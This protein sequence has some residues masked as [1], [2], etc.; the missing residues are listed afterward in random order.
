M[1]KHLIL[2]F[3]AVI[4]ACCSAGNIQAQNCSDSE[5]C[6]YNPA[7]EG[8]VLNAPCLIVETVVE[9]TEGDLA[10]MTTYR[11]FF[12][13]EMPT[14]FVTSVYGNLGTP[15]TLT[16]TTTFYQN[17][18]G[19]ASSQSQNPLL[20]EGFPNL[21]YDS[22]VTIGLSETANA[23]A[24]ESNP[25][26]VPSPNQD[27]IS[28]FDPGGGAAGT[29][30][31]INDIVGGIWYIFNGDANGLPDENNRVLLAQ[32]TT[33]GE[34]G[35]VLNV[36]YFPN[37]GDA[38]TATLSIADAC[39]ATPED[40][41]Y[42]E[43]NEDC[44]GNCLN[45]QDADQICDEVDDCIGTLDACGVC[46][47]PGAVLDCG[48]SEI[49]AGDCDCNGNQLDA[50]GDCGGDCESDLNGNGV[51]DT[52]EN[53]GCTDETAC[54]Y[55]PNATNDDG[56]CAV[57]DA[58][59]VC[60]GPGAVY[61]C[62]CDEQPAGDCDCDGNQ[63]DALGVCGGDCAADADSDGVCD[64][65]D[66]CVGTVDECGVCNGPGAT[67]DCGCDDLPDGACDCDGNVL[68]ALGVCGGSCTADA[69]S[70]GVCD[71]VD[72]CIGTLDACG[73]C[74]G[75]GAIY[76]CGCDEQPAGDCDCDGNQ[77]DA[78]G[79]C[80]GDCP[81]DAD[82]N[83]ICDNLEGSG[84]GD[85]EACN[86]DEFADPP[87]DEPI[88]DYC[89]I[90]EV[91]ATHTD[92][93]LAGMTTYRV[94]VQTLHPTDFLTSVSGN[95]NI[96]LDIST[97]T[98]FYQN[99]LGGATP[100]NV[101][102]LLLPG[103]PDLAY[104]SWVTIGLDGPAN[105]VAGESSATIVNSPNQ[106]WALQFEPGFGAPGGSIEIDDEVGGVWYVLNG[107]A[108]G[109]PDAD[110][111]ILIGQFTTDGELSGT[112]NAQVFPEG[113][114]VNF[115]LLTL[116]IGMGIGCPSGGGGDNCL[117]DDAL[118]ACGGD[119]E[120]DA[121]G[122]GICDDVDDCVGELDACGV[123]NGPGAVYDCGC[124]EQPSGDCDCDGNQSDALGVCGGDCAADADSDGVC[125]N[126]DDCVGTV[127]ECGVCNGPGA[128]GDCGCDD[129]PDGACDC[130]GNV[131]DALGVCGGS[132]TADADSDGVCDNVD[133]CIGTVDAC[134]ICNGPGAIYDCGCDEQPAGDCD[135][136]GNQLDAL[137]V[138]GGDCPA[139]ADQNGICDNIEGSGCGDPEA[140]NFDEFA[141]PPVDEPITDYCTI[142]EVVAT[143]TDGDLAG[144]TTYRVYVQTLHPTDFL[145]SVSGNVN[146]PLDISTTTTFYQN[147]LGGATPENVNPLLL[148][149]FPDLAYDSW[150]TIGL[151]GPANAVAGESSATIVNSP[152]QNWA[153]QFEPGFGAPGGNI[154][155]D[156]EVGGVWYVLNG[157]ANGLPDAD[158]RILIGQFTTD[159]ELS[160]TVN[161][162]VFPEGDNVN[163]LVLTLP[164]GMGVGCPSNNTDDSCLYDDVLGVCG[165]DCEADADGDGIC[166]D[167]DDCV[168]DFD[169]CGICNGPGAIYDCGC[170]EQPSDDCDCDGNQLDA[171]GVCGGDCEADADGD[172]ICDD[173]D[174]CVGELD[175]CGICNGPGAIYDCGCDEQPSDDCDCDGNQLDALGVCGGDCE[176]DADGDGICDDVDDCVGELDACGVCNGPGA[177]Y[178]C[179]CDEQPAD[180]CDCDGNQ[181]DA[182]GV[183]GGD[184]EADAD[185]DGICDDVDDCVGDLDACGICNGPG[186]IYDCGCDEQPSDD[187]DC[188]G[189]QLDA[190]GVCGGDCPAD[191]D[192]DG[193]CDN[194]EI[195][196]CTLESAC[197][198]NP[199][200]TDD[201]GSCTTLDECGVCGGDGIADGDC[202]CD[203]NQL[204][205][206]GVCGGG[207]T[208]DADA[209]G[210]CDDVDDCVGDLDAC[211]VCNGPGAIY[212]CGC[213][214]QPADD[215]D[216]DGNQ[217]DALGV[218]GGDCPSDVDGDGVCDNAEIP[219]CTTESACNYNPLATDDDGSCAVLD[220][221]GDCGG[222]CPSDLNGDGICD[223]DNVFG[224]TEPSACNFNP[225]ADVNNGSC[226]FFS[227]LGCTDSDA[228]NFDNAATI[229][230]GS[231]LFSGCINP[232]ASNYD[233]G[234]DVD[235]GSCLFPGCTD[236]TACN[237]SAQANDEDNSCD[238]SCYGCTNQTA[239]NY[240][241]DATVND[242]SCEFNSCRG[243]TDPDAFNYDAGATIDDNSCLYEGCTNSEA[244]NFD[245]NADINDGSCLYPGCDDITA[246]NYD[247]QANQND[248]S[249]DFSCYGCINISA[250]NYDADATVSDGSCEFVSCRGCTDPDAINFEVGS[251]ID[252]GSCL[253]SGCNDPEAQNYDAN[254]DFNDGSCEYPG[255]LDPAAC[256][257]DVDANVDDGSCDLI[258]CYGC[259]NPAACNYDAT[260]TFPDGSCDLVTCRGCT[261][262]DAINY[263]L[264]ATIDNGS[265]LFTG[266]TDPDASNYDANA[267]Y[268]DGSCIYTGCTN[269][270]ACNFNSSATVDDGSCDTESC[271][272]CIN[273]LA[274]NYDDTAT[275][276]DGSCDLFSCR[277]CT[278]PDAINYDNAATIDDGSCIVVGCLDPEAE[279][280]NANADYNDPD[281]C[282][283]PVVSGC[284]VTIACNYNP[285]ATV[286]DG[287]CDYASCAGCTDPSATN[288]DDTATLND[289][290]CA[291]GMQIA[292]QSMLDGCTLPFACNFGDTENPCEFDSCT[293][294]TVAGA[295]NYDPDATLA[296]TC[297]YPEDLCNGATNVDC[298]CNCL[299]DA[300][301]NQICDEDETGG[302]TNPISCNYDPSAAFDD[303]SCDT[304][305]CG[306][307]TDDSACN[308]DDQALLN[309]GSCDYTSCTG[310]LD[311]AAC[312]YSSTAT[313]ADGSCTYAQEYQDCDGNCLN[314]A[315]SNNIC[316]EYEEEGC[317]DPFACN[318]NSNATI[319]N[320]SCES[321]SCAGCTDSV[322]CNYDQDAVINNGSC[323]YTSCIG[324]TDGTACNY[325]AAATVSS[326]ECTY[327][328][329]AYVDCNGDCLEDANQNGLCDPLEV[330]GCTNT[331][332]CNYNADANLDDGS[333]D[334]TSC[335]GCLDATACNYDSAATQS[336]GNCD[337]ASCQG[338]NDAAACNYDATATQDDG[339]CTYPA[340]L[341]L[342]CNGDCVNDID[343]DGVCDELE[344]PGCDDAAACNYSSSA[345][346]NDGSCDYASCLGCVDAAA[347]NYDAAATQSDGSCDFE[348]C[349]GCMAPN[350]CN[351]D[352]TATQGD[353]SCT[354]PEGLLLDCDGGCINDAD[355][356]GVCDEQETFGC[357]EVGACNFNALATENNG[358][359]DFDSCQGC[360]VPSACNYDPAA[361]Q[362]DGSCDLSG[363]L[364][365]TYADALNYDADATED[366]GSCLFD[367]TGG[368]G[369]CYG[370]LTDDGVIGIADLLEFLIVFDSTCAD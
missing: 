346:D 48:C 44:S 288:Y 43:P 211:G 191:V 53:D 287:N 68:D 61:D 235:D 173:V 283:Y 96:P 34:L 147:L 205:A 157:D 249:C 270:F 259:L 343:G 174:D 176:A 87:V 273:P 301:N 358:S 110:G 306:G 354:Y 137:G 281:L 72:D 163:F 81:A 341:L 327:P 1:M 227:C 105:A 297:F 266:C 263:D 149:G 321:I 331:D 350:A 250:C 365:C 267:D 119:C 242:G 23:S 160:G 260:A 178:D 145:T 138:C 317:T 6:N 300:N 132:C 351:Y 236:I 231:C 216:C 90:T 118:G 148:P 179:G 78:L 108:N 133:D 64:N 121:D 222:D 140:C 154:E 292:G 337:Y 56:S 158:G 22:Y 106:N 352:P 368:G 370:D 220:A 32:L 310:C 200:A 219:G 146:I 248:N 62:G 183:C 277:G 334:L 83:G 367:T 8:G 316:D 181:L 299:N 175:A 275:L 92:G 269:P 203:G 39:E 348:S 127:D 294:C 345:T 75:P 152:N 126:V 70:D 291:Y 156:D 258:S 313:V 362:N 63:P 134:G 125:D 225:A 308:Y 318:F 80:G 123:C 135:C 84:C 95:V 241:L 252:D 31:I 165:G 100:E 215:C 120:A 268:S 279:N 49:P 237:Y 164:I 311:N 71:N 170:D 86:F 11:V 232:D 218:C 272:G 20:F 195:P 187:C 171:L 25:S 153:L 101:N 139:D 325:D 280:Y 111:R 323:D 369:S 208:A 9:H 214:E 180:D 188:D 10:G 67:G 57:V 19:S 59:G 276:S 4:A 206:I 233:A 309:D 329:S 239:C 238:F 246:C 261:N 194:A 74:N 91:V 305:S 166:D 356:D 298:D 97:T 26:L 333:C 28:A 24:G 29:D 197:N 93:D 251:T 103:F 364:G 12:Q 65:V 186:A 289:G 274:C 88:T 190:L 136:D 2:S 320:G 302:C 193:I 349:V 244:F 224:C 54:N 217:L 66:D 131:L 189:N 199:A 144:M 117:Y 361:T 40:C 228:V 130:D 58:C 295:C 33:S 230:D 335:Q 3:C 247:P 204:D 85:P 286:S 167:V 69:D 307:C 172:G 363:C 55:N 114:N 109:L 76:D 357:D 182:L 212:D 150:V 256:N 16:T 142:T 347:C 37:G 116:P 198:Y 315:N 18:L 41:T 104:D 330:G 112:V 355:G 177:V 155:I 184:C 290:S 15:L 7:F 303:G 360:T 79:V 229:D 328:A 336:D 161:A 271:Y 254:A 42:A 98:T 143:H 264:D 209:D 253:Y 124:D 196:G 35:G 282:T 340:G 255:C 223:T 113:D 141:D 107:D 89:T 342:D 322:A 213:D 30:I 151:D 94:Y 14:D 51:C 314:D 296:T 202:D 99:L 278:N 319:D 284:L 285:D 169:A 339:S 326:G 192:G 226:D 129:L 60:D 353:A 207:C 332:A 45:D 77:L 344:V 210:V 304:T 185:G 265:C 27:W 17:Q 262:P 38:V 168:G 359:C 257:F 122:D 159:G 115:M 245:P 240:D 312:N 47:G 324:C 5:A 201:D 82:Q 36:Q 73:I 338:C 221:I 162:Q 13:A 366:N 243:C 234:A 102:P 52:D 50:I 293:G 128:T 21:I 46:N